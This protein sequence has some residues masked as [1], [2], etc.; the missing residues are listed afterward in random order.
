MVPVG[1][2][3]PLGGSS[4]GGS[5]W[6]G[7]SPGEGVGIIHVVLN[8]CG[9]VGVTAGLHLDDVLRVGEGDRKSVV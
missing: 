6:W 9:R 2:V 5:S 1:G 4:F 3:V 7:E 8:T